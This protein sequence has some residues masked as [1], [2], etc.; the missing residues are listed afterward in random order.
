M[1]VEVSKVNMPIAPG[2]YWDLLERD[3]PA[4][5]RRA[6]HSKARTGCLTCKRRRVKC[7]EA[8]PRCARCVKAEL[9]CAG[10][11]NSSGDWRGASKKRP[12]K[13]TTHRHPH[14]RPKAP[15]ASSDLRAVDLVRASLTP[16]YLDVRNAFYFERFQC[17]ILADL[18]TWC[19]AKY[20]RHTILREVLVDKTVQHAALAAA[21]MLMDIEEQQQ[22]Q[23][24]FTQYGNGT[25][26]CTEL[27]KGK[28]NSTSRA[29]CQTQPVNPLSPS[30]A[31][32]KAAL[33]HYTSSLSLC[34]HTLATK[35]VD[36]ATA[37]SSLT[38]TFFF[39]VFELVRGNVSEA[40][41]I[42]ANG[43]KLLD[44]ALKQK[45]PRTGEKVLVPDGEM[46]QIQLAFDRMRVT[47]GL[48]PYFGRTGR[49][50]GGG[51][52]VGGDV[53]ISARRKRRGGCEKEIESE[54]WE[55]E[56][57]EEATPES[58]ALHFELPSPD[59]SVRT[60]QLFWNAFS[61]DFGR[62][63]VRMRGRRHD[64]TLTSS[65]LVAIQA[66]RTKYLSQL[67]HWLPI[68]SDLCLRDPRSAVLCTTK[69]YAQTAI[70]YLNCFLDGSEV[71]YD[72]YLMVFRDIVGSY[73]R[74]L[75]GD[76][77]VPQ[78][79]QE[80]QQ[81]NQTGRQGGR[82]STHLRLT[83]DVD[84]FHIITFTIC[85]C[86]DRATRALA[87]DVFEAM[88]CRQALWTNT[89]LLAA[90]RALAE[91]ENEGR[92]GGEGGEEG[93]G[94]VPPGARYEFVDSCWDFEGR[95]MVAVFVG[96]GGMGT[97]KVPIRF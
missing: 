28:A 76:D 92:E 30:S 2:S 42:L 13:S 84:L 41:R 62:F 87:L 46:R 95:E 77:T 68:L 18:G 82:Q 45:D 89:A 72:Q 27:A 38:A 65:Q 64:L 20:W 69:A 44:H 16:G 40:D 90:L 81:Q 1:K 83:L 66:Q 3:E 23:L 97:V 17:Q 74:L 53:G 80:Q 49:G 26:R 4:K 48:C 67:S 31:H 36:A 15:V 88:T 57:E 85:K 11:D 35:G 10:Y 91:L 60:K 8:K 59:A 79:Q 51:G 63:M 22:K 96:V 71:A 21:A 6:A 47:W 94:F 56:G 39:A 9:T 34:R 33:C 12:Q 37:R 61:S 14:L 50:R 73:R 7:D 29:K 58:R 78:T 19:G 54:R 25:A 5:Q 93:G 32:G 55:E 70:I 43:I 86:R 75:E 52:V 24:T